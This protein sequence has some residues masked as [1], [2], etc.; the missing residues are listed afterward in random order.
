MTFNGH[1]TSALFGPY[2]ALGAGVFFNPSTDWSLGTSVITSSDSSNTVGFDTFDDGLIWSVSAG[3]QY[4]LGDLPG[5]L[6]G[7]FQYA[8]DNNYF[9]YNQGP[10]L[11]PEG[12]RLP[13][14]D[15]SWAFILNGWQYVHVDSSPTKPINLPNGVR[16][17]RASVSG[18]AA[19]SPTRTPT[20]WT[21]A[22][23]SASA[24]VG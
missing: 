23:A 15:D 13:L 14:Q 18:S 5:G 7:T 1:S 9:N 2:C 8:F 21:G 17:C 6:R 3:Y 4:K 11:T 10:Y 12:V 20:P 22:S 16:I 24:G 19:D